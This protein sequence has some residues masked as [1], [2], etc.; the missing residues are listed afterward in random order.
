MEKHLQS[1][2]GRLLS[3][4]DKEIL[5]KVIALVIPMFVM[6]YF[7]LPITLC[8]EFENLMK[9]FWWGQKENERKIH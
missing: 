9:N 8:I 4:G 1:Y 5:I 3:Q 6:I 7:K 2:K